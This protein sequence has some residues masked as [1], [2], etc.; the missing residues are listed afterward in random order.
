MPNDQK[1]ER[2]TLEVS[3]YLD[4]MFAGFREQLSNYLQLIRELR[5]LEARIELAEK[6][7]CLT[8]DHF[9]MMLE[10]SDS[11]G[12]HD[13]SQLAKA[14]FVGK[15]LVDAC[16]ELLRERKRLKPEELRDALNRGSFRFRTT[17]P[18]RE[19]HAALLR[20]KTISREENGDWV[21]VGEQEPIRLAAANDD[22]DIPF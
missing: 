20:Q 5:G 7:V 8:R 19:I 15:R 1:N 14:Q 3:S 22:E 13:W 9:T 16:L 12:P 10:Q 17:S 21:Y 6:T 4:S 2:G 18:L 11:V